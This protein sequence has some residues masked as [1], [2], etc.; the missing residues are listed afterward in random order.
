MALIANG[1][2]SRLPLITAGPI[3]RRVEPKLV[4]VWLALSEP[5]EV[6]VSVWAGRHLKTPLGSTAR[7][8]AQGSE[9]SKAFGE[10]LHL[11][12]VC[13]EATDALEAGQAYSY[14]LA[15]STRSESGKA[16]TLQSL[17]LLADSSGDSKRLPHLALGYADGALP[18]FSLVPAKMEN[19]RIVYGSCRLPEFD[20]P[21]TMALI[22]DLVKDVKTCPHLL[23]LIGD[24]I[25]ADERDEW[26][27]AMVNALG[28]TLIG[29]T[30]SAIE[31]LDL[32][33]RD[34]ESAA[35]R[36]PADLDHFPPATR[37]TLVQYGA[38]MTTTAGRNHLLSFGEFAATYITSWSNAA[39]PVFP[40]SP[41]DDAALDGL[42]DAFLAK[43]KLE[44]SEKQ[45]LLGNLDIGS[46]AQPQDLW[47]EALLG[48]TDADTKSML[49]ANLR[50]FLR[51]RDGLP[52]VR[53]VL[54]NIPTLMMFD[55][56]DVTD[57]WN[58][59]PV[60]MQRVQASPTGRAIVR[61]AL[62]A[63][64]VFQDWGNNPVR[65]RKAADTPAKVLDAVGKLFSDQAPT[66]A[67]TTGLRPWSSVCGQL[68]KLFGLDQ[69]PKR[70]AGR[71]AAV[72]PPMQW[73]WSFTGPGFHLVAL[74]NRTRRSFVSRHGPPGNV[75][76]EAQA[77]QIPTPDKLPAGT[78]VLI[79]AAPLPVMGPGVFDELV[80]PLAY[81]VFDVIDHEK[82][83]KAGLGSQGM[84]G[85]NPDALEVW[86]Q[87]T[88]THEALLARLAQH[89]RVVLLSGDVHNACA[90]AMSYWRKPSGS[91]AD[92]RSLSRIAQFTSS[93]FKN[94]MPGF[95][96]AADR[97]LAVLQGIVS[98][99]Y[100]A[101]RLGWTKKTPAA[102]AFPT[103]VAGKDF[104][105]RDLPPVL[106]RRLS[107]TPMW[108]PTTGW[109]DGTKVNTDKP[110]DWSWRIQAVLDTRQDSRRPDFMQPK[111]LADTVGEAQARVAAL[112]DSK[113][114]SQK[115]GKSNLTLLAAF[116]A[117]AERHRGQWDRLR[118]ARQILLRANFGVLR[119]EQPPKDDQAKAS[120]PDKWI[121]VQEIYTWRAE[122]ANVSEKPVQAMV[123][124]ARL[125]GSDERDD[126]PE[127]KSFPRRSVTALVLDDPD[128]SV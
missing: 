106:R 18:G 44:P 71:Y 127:G 83:N 39:W 48:E 121:A 4:S 75:S 45:K 80:G 64:T 82:T 68:D 22:D 103:K 37:Q 99:D 43:L 96:Q 72:K 47:S 104:S 11:V 33:P 61:N 92:R 107:Q 57:D 16:H 49:K 125:W 27:L 108:L 102:L 36:L 84:P 14:D 120:D 17:G 88:A 34:G 32:P 76:V 53:R 101:E 15:I 69:V 60:W 31:Q 114:N 95:L 119:F 46:E 77:D 98:A 25:Y 67:D 124:K 93:G 59:N 79:V 94:V 116:Q 70:E 111:P 20:Q 55:D 40:G 3:L 62:A 1:V 50:T 26:Q 74:D 10:R 89:P 21:D 30:G 100:G 81:R 78:Q 113:F 118:H 8:V 115:D 7:K 123:Q 9:S 51:F 56:H 66:A 35:R 38:K 128:T 29:G 91:A 63:Y 87:D 122:G 5:A 73:H 110:P 112:V 86:A 19:L 105:R 23:L 109:P 12:L 117:V 2:G 41:T 24:Q 126:T 6:T 90:V 52:R 65:Y 85:T 58:L 13:A 54:A 28:Q 42:V 97:S